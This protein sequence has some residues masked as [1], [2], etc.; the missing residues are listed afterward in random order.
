[1]MRIQALPGDT[2]ELR[3][4]DGKVLTLVCGTDGLVVK[5]NEPGEHIAHERL[6]SFSHRLSAT[7]SSPE[8]SPAWS[9]AAARRAPRRRS[10]T[11]PRH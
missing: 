7:S 9:R 8:R 11:S 3:Q 6:T 1:M 10:T 5:A 4:A 2:I